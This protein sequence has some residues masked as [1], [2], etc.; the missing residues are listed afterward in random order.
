MFLSEINNKIPLSCFLHGFWKIQGGSVVKICATVLSWQLFFIIIIIEINI[1]FITSWYC[2]WDN[3]TKITRI[4]NKMYIVAGYNN[5]IFKLIFYAQLW[6]NSEL[7]M[8]VGLHSKRNRI[9]DLGRLRI[10]TLGRLRITH[11]KARAA[12]QLPPQPCREMI[13]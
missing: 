13:S 5:D 12:S 8:T 4:V 7:I 10:K 11:L 1:Y 3:Q 6:N 2:I 9:K